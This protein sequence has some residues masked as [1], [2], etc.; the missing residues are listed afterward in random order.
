[1]P[2]SIRLL[3]TNPYHEHESYRLEQIHGTFRY[4][5]RRHR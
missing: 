5:A 3:R 1:M 2:L 4:V